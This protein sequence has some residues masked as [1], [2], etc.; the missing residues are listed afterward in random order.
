MPD[1]LHASSS[2]FLGGRQA[3]HCAGN[4]VARADV[5][6]CIFSDFLNPRNSISCCF[7]YLIQPR[8]DATLD[9]APNICVAHYRPATEADGGQDDVDAYCSN[10]VMV[11]KRTEDRFSCILGMR[12]ST[13]G[14]VAWQAE[15]VPGMLL[16]DVCFAVGEYCES[17]MEQH[18]YERRSE[19][20]G[21]E[22]SLP[23]CGITE[24]RADGGW[25]GVL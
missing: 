12:S 14:A 8:E 22:N 13:L 23:S 16:L 3:F 18:C 2:Y 19:P 11:A 4:R 5:V 1:L 6:I 20:Q 7:I 17:Q 15:I 10:P 9:H 25:K 24:V 21:G